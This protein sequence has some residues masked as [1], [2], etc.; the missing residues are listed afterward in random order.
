MDRCAKRNQFVQFIFGII[1]V[2]PQISQQDALGY[3]IFVH[4]FGHLFDDGREFLMQ[5]IFG[6][7]L[8]GGIVNDDEQVNFLVFFGG[9]FFLF[10]RFF[11]FFYG[12]SFRHWFPFFWQRL[13]RRQ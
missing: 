3:H 5:L 8:G 6:H 11:L 10:S 4:F 13:F 1:A 2:L 9:L 12:F 7:L